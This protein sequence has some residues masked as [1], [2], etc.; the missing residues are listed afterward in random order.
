[1]FK[2]LIFILLPFLCFSQIKIEKE[3]ITIKLELEV[4]GKKLFLNDTIY[5]CKNNVRIRVTND[6]IYYYA[7][8]QYLKVKR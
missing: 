8:N 1:M 3:K 5:V 6:S 4:V 2:T 7:K